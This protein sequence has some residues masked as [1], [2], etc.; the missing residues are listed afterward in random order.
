M[1]NVATYEI[2]LN[3][4]LLSLMEDLNTFVSTIERPK[5][6][7]ESWNI[8]MQRYCDELSARMNEIHQALQE[9]AD[10]YSGVMQEI[11]ERIAAYKAGLKDNAGASKMKA[12][13]QTLSDEYEVLFEHLQELKLAGLEGL[14][15]NNHLKPS[16]YARN[17]F[18]VIMGMSGVLMY[19]FILSYQ[20]AMT[21]LLSIFFVFGSL[22]VIRRFHSGFNDFMVDKL[23]GLISRPFERHHTNGSTYMVIALITVVFLFPKH[24]A[25]IGVVVL[26]FADPMAS[27]IGK[28]WGNKKLYRDKSVVGTAA[29]L[30]TAF[31]ATT[32]FM[33]LAMPAL[34]LG[35]TL[36]TA[37]VLAV[38]GM[39]TELFSSRVDDNLSIPILCS[40]AAYLML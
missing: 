29:F 13:Y 37:L 33:L 4:Q 10:E 18:H 35:Y 24:V 8:A 28:R 30:L 11:S 15:R 25:E 19:E 1:S 3:D 23:F 21:V 40:F 39:L 6:K 7:D 36:L 9:K 14:V 22:E 26:A 38:V 27:V 17:I 16:N 32:I 20:Q 31:V 5:L 2:S 12:F 34:S